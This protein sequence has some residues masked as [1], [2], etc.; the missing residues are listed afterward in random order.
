MEDSLSELKDKR[1]IK[2]KNQRNFSQTTQELWKEF[3]RTQHLHHK[4]KPKTH[5]H[6]E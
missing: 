4:T 3:A 6:G 5:G 1:K 2:E